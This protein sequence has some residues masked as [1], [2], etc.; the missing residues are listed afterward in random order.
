MK[1][2]AISRCSGR[3]APA[4]SARPGRPS[5]APDGSRR[6][7][8]RAA[9]PRSRCLE[10]AS[11]PPLCRPLLVVALRRAARPPERHL[12]GEAALAPDPV[13][14]PIAG[15]CHKPRAGVVRLAVAGPSF[16]GDRERLLSGLLGKVEVAE[17]ADQG[18]QHATPLVA[19]RRARSGGRL[20]YRA[21]L[22]RAAEARSRGRARRSRARRR[23][24]RRRTGSS[25]RT[26]PWCRRTGHL[27]SGSGRPGCV[28]SSPSRADAAG[29]CAT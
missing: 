16:G 25:R 22:D 19:R 3:P 17:E 23:R 27:W 21:N 12:G 14:R 15:R 6:T 18:G 7:A 11:R 13:D 2:R 8:A 26:P 20:H 1:A 29:R 5:P 10:A 28:P 24:R 9:R 4:A